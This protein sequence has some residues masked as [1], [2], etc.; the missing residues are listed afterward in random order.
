MFIL[1]VRDNMYEMDTPHIIQRGEDKQLLQ[2]LAW[3]YEEQ[4]DNF[5]RYSVMTEE[6]Y[7]EEMSKDYFNWEE[8][9]YCKYR[10][11]YD[12]E[13]EDLEDIPTR[14]KIRRKNVKATD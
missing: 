10:A 13:L 3:V 5:E 4:A 11:F 9:D 12:N 14:E 1:V 8:W 2:E 7:L 6:H